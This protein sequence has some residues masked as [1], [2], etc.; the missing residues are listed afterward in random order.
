MAIYQPHGP[1]TPRGVRGE[2]LQQTE[3]VDGGCSVGCAPNMCFAKRKWW[4]SERLLLPLLPE[5]GL[6][7]AKVAT[8]LKYL[9]E[10]NVIAI[11]ECYQYDIF[12]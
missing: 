2:T 3:L 8:D 11:A 1:R 7:G 5:I 9:L 12:L 6:G 4:A 10:Q